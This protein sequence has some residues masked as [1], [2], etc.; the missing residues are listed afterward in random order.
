MPDQANK[1][2][3]THKQKHTHSGCKLWMLATHTGS[4]CQ[5][6]LWD[7]QGLVCLF[8]PLLTHFLC[9]F[10]Y[11]CVCTSV[12][13]TSLHLSTCCSFL[14]SISP[15]FLTYFMQ[16]IIVPSIRSL[17]LFSAPVTEKQTHSVFRRLPAHYSPKAAT[18]SLRKGKDKLQEYTCAWYE[19]QIQCQ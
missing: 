1:H 13:S 4:T 15:L 12:H 3:H 2:K 7:S 8:L 17:T 6:V 16:T 19:C 10:V 18:S 11:A 5:L 14:Q 9:E